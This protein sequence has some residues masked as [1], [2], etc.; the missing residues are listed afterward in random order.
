MRKKLIT[1]TPICCFFVLLLIY[2]YKF[3][4]TKNIIYFGDLTRY[5]FPLKFYGTNLIKSGIIP[6]W[7]PYLFCGMPFLGVLQTGVFY[8]PNLIIY[9]GDNFV[10]AYG[11]YIIFHFFISGFFTYLLMRNYRLSKASS[12]VSA[13]IFSFGGY[14]SSVII[15]N[16]TLCS[17]SWLPAIF[18]FFD[19]AIKKQSL[20][21]SF[22]TSIFL[23]LMFLGGEPTVI[24]ITLL[25]LALG[26]FIEFIA[27]VKKELRIPW[28][29]MLCFFSLC[30]CWIL[31]SSFQMLPFLEFISLGK[32]FSQT[33]FEQSAKWSM[34]FSDF[35]NYLIPYAFGNITKGGRY[36]QGQLW[37]ASFYVGLGGLILFSFSLFKLKNRKVFFFLLLTIISILLA[38]GNK[39]FLYKIFY[40]ILPGFNL[41][42][43]PVKFIFLASFSTA[44]LA[45]FGFQFLENRMEGELNVKKITT[46]LLSVNVL[47]AAGVV[48][49]SLYWK[50]IYDFFSRLTFFSVVEDSFKL[51][52]LQGIYLDASAQI[53]FFMIVF[54][55]FI[56]LIIFYFKKNIKKSVFTTC[57]ILLVFADLFYANNAIVRYVDSNMLSACPESYQKIKEA[58]SGK[59]YRIYV[60]KE[61]SEFNNMIYG[62]DMGS[63]YRDAMQR[64]TSNSPMTYKVHDVMGYTSIHLKNYTDVFDIVLNDKEPFNSPVLDIL[65][66]KYFITASSLE[67]MDKDLIFKGRIAKRPVIRNNKKYEY[68]YIYERNGC[69]PRFFLND[70]LKVFKDN[71]SLLE[72]MSSDNFDPAEFVLSE[73]EPDLGHKTD[74]KDLYEKKD[75]DSRIEVI[76]YLPHYISLSVDTG[77]D[78]LLVSGDTYYP[79]W[80][81]SIDGQN[82]KVYKVYNLLRGLYVPKGKHIVSFSY[83]PKSFYLGN[84][85]TIL[86]LMLLLVGGIIFVLKRFSSKK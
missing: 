70:K 20:F 75:A 47:I 53:Y 43:Y 13:I 8:P 18:L 57:F 69:M 11:Y 27:A 61:L 63:A 16:S 64:F 36:I 59:L 31:L 32:R 25:A 86:S 12:L 34:S 83:K 23:A 3:F 77:K 78:S 2:F 44:V 39:S 21:F 54:T 82:A 56:F 76:E 52:K 46:F 79:G 50:N 24:Y 71:K 55:V 67:G 74:P 65:N 80:T 49:F 37:L 73:E 1:L 58:S 7:N 22:V 14:L 68:F 84:I 33:I 81:A 17:V 28:K 60:D 40:A 62:P 42:R 48:F 45:G 35:V 66:V 26:F 6:L 41:I 4:L 51:P 29:M 15:M 38:L 10:R 5:F 85:I 72:Y 30:T 19:K 9:A